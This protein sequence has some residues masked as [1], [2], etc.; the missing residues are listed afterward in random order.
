MGVNR[1]SFK[2][3]KTNQYGLK[4]RHLLGIAE[5]SNPEIRYLLNAAKVFSENEKIPPLLTGKTIANLFFENST[6]TRGS[7]EIA[8]R[9]LHGQVLNFSP[10]TS[11]LKKGETILD[12][13]KNLEAMHPHAMVVRAPS[14]GT[15]MVL[16]ENIN[17]P[18]INAGDGFHEHPTQ[19]LLD[20]FTIEQRLGSVS[21]KKILIMGDIAHSRV[22]RSNIHILKKLGASVAVCAPPT[23][24]PPDPKILGVEYSARP[25]TFLPEMDVVMTLRIQLERQDQIQLPSL[26]EYARFWGL[27]RERV[28][29]LKPEA[30]ILHPGPI[31]RG[32][33]LDPEVADSTRSVILS[34][35]S[36]GVLIR[37][38]VLAAVCN[39]EG[40]EKWLNPSS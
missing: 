34:Q 37:M 29:L 7:F 17:L 20:V 28:K 22:A 3:M 26:S 27:D 14:A 19:A 32:V 5:L 35:V 15:P 13:A 8:T 21:G 12:T 4:K 11:S 2:L 10:S 36:N 30:I 24:L 31:N 33:E 1:L 18:I 16:A 6:R 23:L 39:P 40:L 38:A 9:R 25:E